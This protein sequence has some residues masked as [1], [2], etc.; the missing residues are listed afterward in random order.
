MNTIPVLS[1]SSFSLISFRVHSLSTRHESIERRDRFQIDTSSTTTSTTVGTTPGF[2]LFPT[3]GDTACTTI[4]TCHVNP[5]R[6][7]EFPLR[8]VLVALGFV[9]RQRKL[10]VGVKNVVVNGAALC[11]LQY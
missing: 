5:S 9:A 3:K 7:K 1:R 10:P 11:C 4:T 2:S 6:V 8:I